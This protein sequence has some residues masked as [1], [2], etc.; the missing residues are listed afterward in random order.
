MDYMHAVDEAHALGKR[1]GKAALAGDYRLESGLYA[2]AARIFRAITPSEAAEARR[3]Y[4]QGYREATG[5]PT[6]Q[7]A[8]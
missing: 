6:L 2:F 1:A 3:A 8:A 5:F 4:R 7:D